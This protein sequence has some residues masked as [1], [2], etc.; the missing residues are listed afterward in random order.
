MNGQ[1]LNS[2]RYEMSLKRITSPVMPSKLPKVKMDLAGL[3][4]YAKQKGVSL[5]ELTEE[6]RSRFISIR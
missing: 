3:S 6:E 2:K 4:R 1:M 5:Y